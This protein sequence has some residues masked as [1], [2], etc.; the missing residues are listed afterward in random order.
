MSNKLYQN[1]NLIPELVLEDILRKTISHESE[2]DI[3][4]DESVARSSTKTYNKYATGTRMREYISEEFEARHGPPA[5]RVLSS[6]TALKFMVLDR[7]SLSGR[8]S[9]V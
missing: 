5:R 8:D 1:I 9:F 4:W 7:I 6:L 2:I 3:R